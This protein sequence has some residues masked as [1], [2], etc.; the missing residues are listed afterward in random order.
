MPPMN[1]DSESSESGTGA[2]TG[3]GTVTIN[4]FV[5]TIL[6]VGVIKLFLFLIW[7]NNLERMSTGPDNLG[8]IFKTFSVRNLR[9]FIIS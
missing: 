7:K 6:G 3:A 8:P 2:G 1:E 9:T 5:T 4:L